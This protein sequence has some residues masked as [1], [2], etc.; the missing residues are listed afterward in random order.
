M[1]KDLNMTTFE[2]GVAVGITCIMAAFSCMFAG[3]LNE[4]FGRRKSIMLSSVLF[5]IGACGMV[6]CEG[7]ITATLSRACL[8]LAIGMQ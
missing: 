5:T 8:G 3:P 6:L 7:T 4:R 1:Q 2:K